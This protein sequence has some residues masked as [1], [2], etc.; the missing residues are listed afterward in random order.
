MPNPQCLGV[1]YPFLTRYPI[2]NLGIF[3]M[4]FPYKRYLYTSPRA[5][6]F[7]IDWVCDEKWVSNGAHQHTVGVLGAWHGY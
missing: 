5:E 4:T 2:Y 1:G 3:C 6:K 7:C